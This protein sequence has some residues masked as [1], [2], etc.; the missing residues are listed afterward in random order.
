MTNSSPTLPPDIEDNVRLAL[1]EDVGS[2]DI[3]AELVAIDQQVTAAIFCKEA[4]V[5]CGSAWV[6][7]AF[8][9]VDPDLS[10]NWQI[11]EG[12]AIHV[13][14]RILTIS[15][16]ARS[17]LTAER[18]ALNFLQT[19]SG[20]ATVSRYFANL[21]AHTKVN[22]L[23]TRKTLPGLR[24]AQ[25]YAVRTGGCHNHRMGLYD[26]FLIKENHIAAC[27]SIANAISQA[28]ALGYE[29][30]VEIEVQNLEQLQA[31]IQAGADVVMLD[32]FN[33]TQIVDAVALN[34]GRVKLEASGGIDEST[35]VKIAETG[36]DYISIGGLTKHCH[37][38]DFT[39]LLNPD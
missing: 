31:A 10:L 36:V 34:A 8:K 5:L 30:T 12:E 18:T 11:E 38:I 20:T 16:S 24:N 33:L 23:D 9:M 7:S 25:K 22:L 17:I 6:S 28:R 4:A 39:L 1:A 14:T 13:G 27:G 35:L 37:A 32:N 3:T 29:K 21:V 2:G 26:A 19:L 15:G